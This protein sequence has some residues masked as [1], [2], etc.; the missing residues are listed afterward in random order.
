MPFGDGA[1]GDQISVILASKVLNEVVCS[2]LLT[3]EAVVLFKIQ[4]IS[5]KTANSLSSDLWSYTS[6]DTTKHRFYGQR[7]G[8]STNPYLPTPVCMADMLL[9]GTY[10]VHVWGPGLIIV[11]IET[12]S[13]CRDAMRG[14]YN[15][16]HKM[17]V[18]YLIINRVKRI[19]TGM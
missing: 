13:P 15:T 7:E 1:F 10:P 14:K 2:N 11:Q 17:Y 19:I 8:S 6:S 18:Y 5:S 12:P 16:V 4:E 9:D 3:L